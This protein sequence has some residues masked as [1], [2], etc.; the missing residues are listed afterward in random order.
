MVPVPVTGYLHTLDPFAI[1]VTETFGIR[2]Y[3][4]S[5]LAGFLAGYFIILWLAQRRKAVIPAELVG[6]FVFTIALGTII[7][8]RL[9]Y[10]LFYSPDLLLR[11]RGDFPFWGV[12]AVNEGG[13]ASHGGIIGIIL[14]SVYYGK[15]YNI[16]IAHLCDLTTLGGTLGVFFGR[17]ANFINGELVGRPSSP[18]LAWAV[19]FPQDMLLW[20]AQEPARLST[21]TP[22]VEQFG[23]QSSLW[24][25]WI[26]QI[27]TNYSSWQA[28]E[29]ILHQIIE[30]AQNGNQAVI[31]GLTPVLTARHPSQL[32]EAFL[33]GLFLFLVLFFIWRR[34]QKPGVITGWF[35][36]LYSVVR[37]IG[38]QFRMPDAHIGFQIFGLTRGQILSFGMLAAGILFLLRFSRRSVEPIGGWRQVSP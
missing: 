1:K 16:P 23:I 32:Y 31:E 33:E 7:G 5:Y 20:P 28:V 22:L 34:P 6:D 21:L 17:I 9:G 3:G 27:R 26:S 10:C 12:L 37:I 11:F 36:T 8:G 2:W 25:Q 38:E 35:L 14:A 15:R 13:M 30:A 19:Q 4:L 18:D 24:Q 29:R